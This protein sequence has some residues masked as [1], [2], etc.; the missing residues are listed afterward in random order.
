MLASV[1]G[2][3]CVSTDHFVISGMTNVEA[4]RVLYRHFMSQSGRADVFVKLDADMVLRG[5][6][7]L[8]LIAQ[9]FSEDSELDHAVF[10]VHD[11]I[12]DSLIVGL[13]AFSDRV[14]WDEVGE[15]LFVDAPPR[16]EGS[17]KL[18]G[19]IGAIADHACNPTPF[20]CFRFGVHRMSKVVQRGRIILDIGQSEMQWRLLCSVWAA[21]QKDRDPRRLLALIGAQ[22]SARN[23]RIN[24]PLAYRD[25]QVKLEFARVAGIDD[26]AQ[27]ELALSSL[28]RSK[29]GRW[30]FIFSLTGARR[31]IARALRLLVFGFRRVI[32][33]FGR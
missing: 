2:Q 26:S 6:Y 9:K 21:Y 32:K 10:F 30:W 23:Y 24:G 19:E 29:T 12:S 7:A 5:T 27:L 18:F 8:A 16:Y 1:Q 31:A 17:K 4:H 14:V 22:W 20:Q 13:H 25:D 33:P 3:L 28:W 15:D 11:W